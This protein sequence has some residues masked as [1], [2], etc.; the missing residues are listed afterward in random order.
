MQ[1]FKDWKDAYATVLDTTVEASLMIKL[2]NL[3]QDLL[4][5]PG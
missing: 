2:N 1:K 3:E 4:V 5:S